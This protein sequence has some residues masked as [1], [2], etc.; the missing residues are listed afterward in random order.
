M[1]PFRASKLQTMLHPSPSRASRHILCVTLFATICLIPHAFAQT[2]SPANSPAAVPAGMLPPVP[3]PPP[4]THLAPPIVSGKQLREAD[5]AYLEGARQIERKNLVAAM[6]AFERA[7]RLAPNNRDYA[8]A[9]IVAR[10]NRVTELVQTSAR[11]RAHGDIPQAEKLLNEARTLDP[12]SREVAQHFDAAPPTPPT[13][14]PVRPGLFYSHADPSTFPAADIASTLAGPVELTPLPGKKSLHLHGQAQ[15]VL[16]SL[17]TQFGITTVFDPT[18]SGGRSIDIDMDNATFADATRIVNMAARTFAVAVQPKVVLLAKDDQEMRDQ[19]VPEVE[20]T[21]Y[22]PGL[23]NDQMQELGNVARNV[24]DLK[25]VATSATG[26]YLLLRG[27]ENILRQVNATYDDML[28]GGSEVLF[29]IKLYEIDTTH[30][31]DIGAKPPAYAQAFDIAQTA[32]S[33]ISS[34][35]DIIN[36]AIQNGLLVLTG[37]PLTD[38]LAELGI[39]AAAGVTG[40]SQFTSL[41]GYIG[42]YDKLPLLGVS[43]GPS[44][45]DLLLNS[46]DT[47]LLDAVQLRSSN[48]M[49]VNFRAGSRYPVVTAQYSSGLGSS[50]PSSIAGLSSA[51]AALLAQYAGAS[52]VTVPQFQFEDL[53]ITLKLTPQ[54]HHN[55]EVALAIDLKLEALAG[56]SIDSIPI[57]N[58]RALTSTIAIPTGQT[59]LLAALVNRNEIRGLTGVPGLSEI[60]GFQ[61]TDQDIEK[62]TTELVITITPHIVRSGRLNIASRR[63]STQH[64]TAAPQ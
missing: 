23:T 64:S 56:G 29:D 21:I 49:P 36:A 17:Y 63:L 10:E 20:E 15:S 7:T 26:G 62:N 51:A 12:E 16:R 61:G 4:P 45:F 18:V 33:L 32:S 8:L 53:G 14:T 46:S 3:A 34:N 30:K 37:N 38:T 27:D 25:Q 44:S 58:N 13:P 2:T 57:L 52:S 42:T 19:L 43:T 31:R 11:A 9:L 40:T 1:S 28:D 54:V 39:L 55:D 24:F 22:L 41:L 47:R 5:D 50:L 6:Q 35:Q 60:P 48:K 59:A